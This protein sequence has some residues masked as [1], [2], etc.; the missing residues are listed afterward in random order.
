MIPF[1]CVK[2]FILLDAGISY[3]EMSKGIDEAVKNIIAFV[4][5]NAIQIEQYTLNG[6]YIKTFLSA[7]DASYE[8]K[9]TLRHIYGVCDGERK[10]CGGFI[11]KYKNTKEGDFYGDIK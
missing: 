4:E 3:Y 6:T 9:A 10:S 7:K 2:I 11:W 5:K 8:T 1:K